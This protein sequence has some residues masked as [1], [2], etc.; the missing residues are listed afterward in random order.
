MDNNN[1]ETDSRKLGAAFLIVGWLIFIMLVALI[2]NGT[3][4]RTKAPSISESEAGKQITITRDYDAH[5]RIKGSI[6]GTP[7]TFLI[8]TGATSI[9]VSDSIARRANLKR[10]A[11]LT[12]QTAGGSSVGYFTMVDKLM[13]ADVEVKD[14][15]A[16]II[17]DMGGIEALLGMNVL[18]QF[19]IQQNKDQMI[20]TVPS[21]HQ[22]P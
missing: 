3:V 21:P 19:I 6:N 5:F 22:Q 15:S 12:T 2:T 9:A 4:F 16:V 18:Q 10:E 7:V 1:T 20:L 17:P 8:D 14:I 13:I 11:Q